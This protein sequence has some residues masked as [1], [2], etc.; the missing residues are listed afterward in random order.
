MKL[1]KQY[2][3]FIIVFSLLIIS[4]IYRIQNPFIQKEV[5]VL[6]YTG[7]K[8]DKINLGK[9]RSKTGE[10][11]FSKLASRFLNRSEFSGE[12]VNDLFS[13]KNNSG[14]FNGGMENMG[15]KRGITQEKIGYDED[16][17]VDPI[18][19]ISKSLLSYKFYGSYKSQETRAIFLVKDKLVLVASVG[20][21]IEG[22]YLIEELQDNYIRIKA[23]DLNE[24]IHIDMR[25][26]NND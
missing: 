7:K 12:I 20:D 10:G 19:K 21:R 22:K 16:I 23:L 17:E 3:I 18:K 24:T 9:N 2:V 5:D 26:F 8:T 14:G 4:I 6:T 15:Q 11:Q 1:N 13:L 25:E